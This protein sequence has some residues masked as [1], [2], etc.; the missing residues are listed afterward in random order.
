MRVGLLTQIQC[1]GLG[2]NIAVDEIP[3][4]KRFLQIKCETYAKQVLRRTGQLTTSTLNRGR[5]LL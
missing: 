4:V 3:G 5:A 2:T 1:L